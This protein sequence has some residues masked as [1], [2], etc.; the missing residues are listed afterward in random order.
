MHEFY[1]VRTVL[2]MI[3]VGSKEGMLCVGCLETRLGRELCRA[4]FTTAYINRPEWGSKSAR[5]MDR[6]K[7]TG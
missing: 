4:D 2:W 6:L 3:A 7:R 1:F 5:L